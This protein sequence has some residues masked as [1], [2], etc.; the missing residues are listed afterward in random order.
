[1]GEV[2]RK[3]AVALRYGSAVLA[4]GLLVLAAVWLRPSPQP[5]RDSSVSI[6]ARCALAAGDDVDAGTIRIRCGLDQ[7]QVARLVDKA[8]ADL[9]LAALIEQAR[10]GKPPEG[11]ALTA[12]AERLGVPPDALR[13][14]VMRFTRTPVVAEIGPPPSP[15]EPQHTPD[16]ASPTAAARMAPAEVPRRLVEL[17]A[18]CAAVAGRDLHAADVDIQCLRDEDINRFVKTLLAEAKIDALIADLRHA[19]LSP[20]AAAQRVSAAVGLT[21]KAAEEVLRGI[22]LQL[23]NATQTIAERLG[24]QLGVAANLLRVTTAAEELRR[25]QTMFTEAMTGNRAAPGQQDIERAV[26]TL[27]TA[28]A[29]LDPSRD[30]EGLITAAGLIREG[31]DLAARG[32]RQEAAS[33]FGAAADALAEAQSLARAGLLARI[34]ELTV[35]PSAND[36]QDTSRLPASIALYERVR[37]AL[38]GPWVT[39]ST[40]EAAFLT[41]VGERRGDAATLRKAVAMLETAL[42]SLQPADAPDLWVRAQKQLGTALLRLGE[43]VDDIA[44]L[45]RAAA[46]YDSAAAQTDREAN[47]SS[48]TA[49]ILNKTSTLAAIAS[50]TD[51]AARL[52][53]AVRSFDPLVESM[54]P[55]RDGLIWAMVMHNRAMALARLARAQHDPA[56]LEAAIAGFEQA[57]SVETPDGDLDGWVHGEKQVAHALLTLGMW[58]NDRATLARSAETYEAVLGHLSREAHPA[59]WAGAQGGV[60]DARFRL[61][62]QAHDPADADAAIRAYAAAQQCYNRDTQRVTWAQATRTLGLTMAIVASDRRQG[63]DLDRSVEMLRQ[64]LAAFE[65]EEDARE[66]AETRFNFAA[67]LAAAA[68]ARRDH[69]LHDQALEAA[70]RAS[71]EFAALGDTERQGHAD[72]LVKGLSKPTAATNR[73]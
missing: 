68:D 44:I 64:A 58:R 41:E 30:T 53:T 47:R 22:D 52:K 29:Q 37:A 25:L 21:P 5:T 70:T 9:G 10:H 57:L 24:S 46:A 14:A 27:D 32:K 33:R 11:P 42:T 67:A 49:L 43:Q 69:A 2:V 17:H 35:S 6:S 55:D 18:D 16:R 13:S 61:W 54:S 36:L 71:G 19:A 51:D 40:R 12:T 50:R 38:A 63:A 34:A 20:E 62:Q 15:T 72:D 3:S 45:E 66:I 60:G 4:G 26:K 73:Q 1:M 39:A 65:A 7:G 56:G 31:T 8:L 23:P 48:W 28:I 59:S